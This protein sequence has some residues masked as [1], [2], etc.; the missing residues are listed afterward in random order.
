MRKLAE[1]TAL[2]AQQMMTYSNVQTHIS[3][4]VNQIESMAEIIDEGNKTT[5]DW[6]LEE[7]VQYVVNGDPSNI[8]AA[9]ENKAPLP[10][11]FPP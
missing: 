2:Y 4:F 8:S 7:I 6:K 9:M 1:E 3:S 10:R 5:T 11:K